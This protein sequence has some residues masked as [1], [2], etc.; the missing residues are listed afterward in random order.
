MFSTVTGN[1]W[2]LLDMRVCE[3]HPPRSQV[4]LSV[5]CRP[6]F[7]GPMAGFATPRAYTRRLSPPIYAIPRGDIIPGNSLSTVHS[8]MSYSNTIKALGIL[9][10]SHTTGNHFS[11]PSLST[12]IKRLNFPYMQ[13]PFIYCC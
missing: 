7:I 2:T 11:Y 3:R 1:D 10:F 5:F 12:V 8:Q 9:I 4:V 6:T 13:D